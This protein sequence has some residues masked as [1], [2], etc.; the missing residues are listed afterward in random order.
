MERFCGA[1]ARCNKNQHLPF[2]S[3]NRRVMEVAQLSQIKLIYGLTDV[4]DLEDRRN[5]IATGS[6]YQGY[7]NS[8]FVRPRRHGPLELSILKTLAEY[9]GPVVDAETQMVYHKLKNRSFEQWGKLQLIGGDGGDMIRGRAF[10]SDSETPR[11][12]ASYVKVC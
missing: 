3:L 7:P 8:V 9:L 11:R 5:N 6:Q 2:L 12:D 1:L 4:L 10:M